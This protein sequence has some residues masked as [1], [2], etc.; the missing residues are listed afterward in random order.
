MRRKLCLSDTQN[1][2]KQTPAPA[3]ITVRG[4]STEPLSQ[5]RLYREVSFKEDIFIGLAAID[6]L[7]F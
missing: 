2:T 7:S 1:W 6:F 3:V 4:D 5:K